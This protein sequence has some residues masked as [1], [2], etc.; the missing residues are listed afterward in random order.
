MSAFRNPPKTK[1]LTGFFVSM[2]LASPLVVLAHFY[3]R[4]LHG[5][6]PWNGDSIAIPIFGYWMLPFPLSVLLLVVGLRRYVPGAFLLAWNKARFWESF[7]WSALSLYLLLVT[8][9][10]ILDGIYGRLYWVS[11]FF[12][13]QL[14]WITILRASIVSYEPR[15]T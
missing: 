14:Y 5:D 8:W 15:S 13:P 9:G 4:L 11:I 2:V 6:Y 3:L 10:M 1:W 7:G 12:G